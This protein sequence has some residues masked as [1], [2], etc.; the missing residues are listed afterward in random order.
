MVDPKD[1]AAGARA[2]VKAA[3]RRCLNCSEPLAG[4]FCAGCGQR[5]VPADPTI[6]ELAGDAWQELSGY[7]G[8]IL[9]TFRA[10]LRPGKLT[11]EYLQGRRARYL[12]PVRIY[13]MV[14]V[15]YFLVAAAAPQI[16]GGMR[17]GLTDTEGNR[18][19]VTAEERA[20]M[21]NSLD[22]IP[23]FARP[24]VKSMAE[25][26]DGFRARLFTIMPRV[27]FGMLPIFGAIIAV[28]YRRHHFPAAL[29]F[30]AYAHSFAFLLFAVS[31]ATK[32]SY[33]PAIAAT[34]AIIA[35]A[36]VAVYV[37]KSLRVVFGGGW[38]VTI[39]KALGIGFAYLL[40]SVPAFIIILIW[41][42]VV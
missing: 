24:M 20:A 1:V 14:S 42:S 25:D 32:F 2:V 13:L 34:A 37:L 27:F 10:L 3:D 22:E 36:G 15:L 33:S 41:A 16:G 11:L 38:P 29:V 40:L 26:P 12:S 5:S 28:F 17:I 30:A 8:R 23:W 35:L 39:L 9:N 21:L 4:A 31:E 18:A 19:S 6:K 7:D